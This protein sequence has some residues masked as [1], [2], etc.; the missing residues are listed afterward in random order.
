[1]SVQSRTKT[2]SRNGKP[3][4]VAVWYARVYLGNGQYEK[5]SFP[6]KGL[7]EEWERDKRARLSRERAGMEVEQPPI[8]FNALCDL[9][10]ANYTGKKRGWFESMLAY[11]RAE[12]GHVQVRRLRPEQIGKWLHN[13]ILR[14]K[15]PH[16]LLKPKTRQHIRDA[17]QQ[18]LGAGIEW[19]YL[20]RSPLRKG[21][22]QAPQTG[23]EPTTV[24]PFESWEEVVKVADATGRTMDGALIRLIC[25]TGLRPE[26]AF[27]LEPRDIDTKNK[28]LHVQRVWVDGELV[29]A[30]KTPGA[31]RT[32]TLSAPALRALAD[33]PWPLAKDSPLFT[34]PE[35]GRLN[36]DNWRRRVWNK[37]IGVAGVKHRPL[38][39]MRHTY[40]TLAL[41]QGC[42]LEWISE[43]MGHTDIRT[44]K[45]HYARFIK[46]VDDRMRALLDQLEDTTNA[47]AQSL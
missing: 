4:K 23:H 46:K 34:A 37:A 27:G 35:G 15:P 42:T 2:V 1:M 29:D 6:T 22:V 40:A 21:A 12:F 9:Y 36:I 25:A 13:D 7:A 44:T 47:D 8:T 3:V 28:V 38:Y 5:A 26:E 32:V 16:D 20:S 19:G 30:G 43:Q 14:R 17:M 31:L 24:S 33:I 41:G 18:V 45:K 39:Q 11:S 10:L